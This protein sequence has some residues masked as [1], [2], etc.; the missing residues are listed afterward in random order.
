VG[1]EGRKIKRMDTW[2]GLKR[3]SKL[4]ALKKTVPNTHNTR[5]LKKNALPPNKNE[6]NCKT[7]S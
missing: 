3:P 1:G 5:F 2:G 6:F 7:A 4:E